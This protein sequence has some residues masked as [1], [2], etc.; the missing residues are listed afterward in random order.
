MYHRLEIRDL[1]AVLSSQI[2]VQAKQSF[3][4]YGMNSF[5]STVTVL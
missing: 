2:I 4:L 1:S 5:F 3:A